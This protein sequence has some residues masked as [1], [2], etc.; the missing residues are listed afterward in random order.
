M[1][2]HRTGP[3]LTLID[4]LPNFSMLHAFLQKHFSYL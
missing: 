4:Y 2:N 1:V 3:L